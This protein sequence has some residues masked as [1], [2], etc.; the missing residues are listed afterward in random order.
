MVV[1][2]APRMRIAAIVS[3]LLLSGA[4]RAEVHVA[5]AGKVS[6]DVPKDYKLE[7][8]DDMVRGAS[9]DND[10]AIFLW[11]VDQPG[12]KQAIKLLAGR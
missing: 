6:I 1:S 4:A 11:I 3:I 2:Y 7:T 8:K 12:A 5:K 9:A 10:V